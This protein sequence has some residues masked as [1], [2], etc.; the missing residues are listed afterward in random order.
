MAINL[1][2]L[3]STAFLYISLNFFTFISPSSDGNEH[4]YSMS[5]NVEGEAYNWDYGTI[6]NPHL[7]RL[8]DR[9]DPTTIATDLCDRYTDEAIA[10][11]SHSIVNANSDP[12]ADG[13]RSGNKGRTCTYSVSPPGFIVPLYWDPI[14]LRFVLMTRPA[15]DYST[16]TSFAI[17]T[18]SG[19]T[20]MVS[21]DAAIYTSESTEEFYSST[22][23]STNSTS[24][25]SNE[26]YLGN[27]ECE[28]N[29][30]NVN[31]VNTCLNKEDRVS[32]IHV[33]L[34]LNG[35]ISLQLLSYFF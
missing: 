18:T 12:S 13:G 17:W 34:T 4:A 28:I 29:K 20:Q 1:S 11:G 8:V 32:L 3:H 7:V 27:L 31:G 19:H 23:Y 14:L 2:I 30:E 10:N 9:S 15:G 6:F 26:D 22:V 25:Y 24:T 16:S 21:N 35:Y 33:D 5:D